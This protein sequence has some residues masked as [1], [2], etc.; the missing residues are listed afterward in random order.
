MVVLIFGEFD[1]RGRDLAAAGQLLG[2]LQRRAAQL[3][4]RSA[5]AIQADD[6]R[7]GQ[8]RRNV[9][10]LGFRLLRGCCVADARVGLRERLVELGRLRLE[11]ERALEIFDRIGIALLPHADLAQH[12]E[13]DGLIRMLARRALEHLARAVGVAEIDQR[14]RQ[15]VADRQ[16]HFVEFQRRLEIGARLGVLFEVASDDAAQVHPAP[17]LGIDLR[18]VIERDS[19]SLLETGSRIGR[20]DIGIDLRQR[21]ADQLAVCLVEFGARGLDLGGVGGRKLRRV[22]G[23]KRLEQPLGSRRRQGKDQSDAKRAAQQTFLDR[24][25]NSISLV[26]PARG[27]PALGQVRPHSLAARQARSQP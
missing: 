22:D 16:V 5:A 14:V 12:R 26:G 4:R 24:H 7:I 17:V 3:L 9:A 6:Q 10:G 27:A 19:S 11:F 15:A 20:A 21:R 18:G 23:R 13:R 1:P 25:V 2:L 8:A